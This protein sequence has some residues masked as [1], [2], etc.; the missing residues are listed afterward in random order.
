LKKK[1]EK[2]KM[3]TIAYLIIDDKVAH[4]KNPHSKCYKTVYF[5][6]NDRII[7]FLGKEKLFSGFYKRFSDYIAISGAYDPFWNVEIKKHKITNNLYFYRLEQ[8]EKK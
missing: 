1:E 6:E 2:K 5:L 3:I 7:R 4:P 8:K